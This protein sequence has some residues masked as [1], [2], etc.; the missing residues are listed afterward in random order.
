MFFYFR[1]IL[2]KSNERTKTATISL[3]ERFPSIGIA[4][5]HRLPYSLL[6][7]TNK[8]HATIPITLFV[9]QNDSSS[10][11]PRFNVN[12]LPTKLILTESN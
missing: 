3:S 1:D 5:F 12:F 7:Q 6:N 10:H 4:I 2:A 8:T 11:Y 9:L